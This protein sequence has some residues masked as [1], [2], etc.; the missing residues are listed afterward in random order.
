ML[1][2]LAANEPYTFRSLVEQVQQMCNL[3]LLNHPKHGH[4]ASSIV[5]EKKPD[6]SRKW[7]NQQK[8]A[9]SLWNYN[10]LREKQQAQAQ[11]QQ[12]ATN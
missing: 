12:T 8:A 5:T 6:E 1:S 3:P 7:S 11:Q 9:R 4:I 2:D 10:H